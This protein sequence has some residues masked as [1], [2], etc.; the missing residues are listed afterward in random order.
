MKY[1]FNKLLCWLGIHRYK[2]IDVSYR[3]GSGDSVEII[4]CRV[5]GIRKIRTK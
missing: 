1:K 4:E 5:C 2:I 3:F